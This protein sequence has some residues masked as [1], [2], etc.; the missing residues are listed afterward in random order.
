MD[1]RSCIEAEKWSVPC[2][3]VTGIVDFRGTG[4]PGTL[5]SDNRNKTL[6][7]DQCL[8]SALCERDYGPIRI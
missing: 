8:D 7:L 2:I 6:T 3:I 4:L 1:F 5:A